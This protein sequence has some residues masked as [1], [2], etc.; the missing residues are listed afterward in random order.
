MGGDFNELID[1]RDKYGGRNI[2]QRCA[3]SLIDCLNFCNLVDLGFKGCKY[4][5]SNH[6]KKKY[7]NHGKI[8]QDILERGLA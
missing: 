3:K 6:R 1:T 8:G 7:L 4:T 5:W 2:N